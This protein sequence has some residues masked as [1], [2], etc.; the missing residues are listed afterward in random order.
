MRTSDRFG[1]AEP[2]VAALAELAA[3]RLLPRLSEALVI[4]RG[5]IGGESK[6]RTTT[7][8]AAA[9]TL[10]Q[11]CWLKRRMPRELISG[12]NVRYL[13]HRPRVVPSRSELM[14]RL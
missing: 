1:R 9:A 3:Q 8:G 11:R 10:R 2:D 6:G 12:R 5:F 14:D 13:H 4:T 7:L